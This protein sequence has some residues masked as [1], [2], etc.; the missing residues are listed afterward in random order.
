MNNKPSKFWTS[1]FKWFCKDDFF[2]ELQ[3][4]LEEKFCENMERHGASKAKS[5]YRAEVIKMIRPSVLR[6][7][8]FILN[9]SQLSL[10]QIH[11]KLAFR[12]IYR[13]KVFSAVNI[14]GLAAAL[15]ASLFLV[16]ILYTGHTLDSHHKDSHRIYR[17]STYTHDIKSGDFKLATVSYPLADKLRNQIPEM[18]DLT[19][20]E[21]YRSE[22]FN[23][24]GVETRIKGLHT[25]PSFFELFSFEP[26]HGDIALVFEDHQSIAITDELSKRLF[27]DEDP[28][29]KV[30]QNGKVVRAII[31]SPLGKSHINFDFIGHLDAKKQNITSPDGDLWDP[32][33]MRYAYF[34]LASGATISKVNE[35]L[36][37]LSSEINETKLNKDRTYQ[38]ASQYITDIIFG[39]EEYNSLGFF[40]S[41]KNSIMFYVL[42]GVLL[43]LACFNYTNMSVARA[44]Q[45]TKEISIRKVAGSKRSQII[46]QFL[47][48]TVLFSLIGLFLGILLY[49][50]F[51]PQF[52]LMVP[53][54]VPVI[55]PNI[56]IEILLVF[57]L[58]TSL[59]GLMAGII[60][61]LYFANTSPL[62]IFNSKVK[63]KR[64]SLLTLRKVLVTLQLTLSMFC[65]L[66]IS[67]GFSQYQTLISTRF[68]FQKEQVVSIK[69]DKAELPLLKQEF[70]RIPEVKAI[71][72]ASSLPGMEL[73]S[74]F[75]LKEVGKM[76]SLFV[77]I[78]TTDT[79]FEQVF[80]P[81]LLRGEFFKPKATGTGHGQMLVDRLFLSSFN[82]PEE[83]AI[84]R[85]FKTRN[86]TIQYEITGVLDDFVLGSLISGRHVPSALIHLEQPFMPSHLA[87]RLQQGDAQSALD[88]LEAAW[89]EIKP[90]E[91][92]MPVFLD[93]AIED[94]YRQLQD[95]IKLLSFL[96]IV[97]IGI[98]LLGQLGMALYN[99]ET[100]VKEIGVR[101]VLGARLFSIV[102]LLLKSTLIS[103]VIA[104]VIATPGIIYFFREVIF[105]GMRVTTD[106]G[107]PELGTGIL[108]LSLFVILLVVIQTRKI[109]MAN[110]AESL[111][112]E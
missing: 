12:N 57:I 86:S 9:L 66:F 53:D 24:D 30:T 3:G 104:S 11:L 59:V 100:R 46:G 97:I 79:D 29:G 38:L 112:N 101:K 52:M 73:V 62:A 32:M 42:L 16:N 88:K 80:E 106:I 36:S 63:S 22:I 85:I 40:M 103:L 50:A 28:L 17:V 37:L 6:T 93:N 81:G 78:A 76:D 31:E 56:N 74:G 21:S 65:I 89:Q 99:A 69:A 64:L 1:L 61:S 84:G 45:R 87:I 102:K 109:A 34:K 43:L 23:V 26:I 54:I 39:D 41:R 105:V 110:P 5:L 98:S 18:S 70:L 94:S 71:S 44:I 14:F 20:I 10:F 95:V 8:K 67:V 107:I 68:N 90:E 55:T 33:G 7:P 48:E 60:P 2:E 4:D 92:F 72:I 35:K 83:E 58:F 91:R 27:P 15:S 108:L 82:I 47:V 96:G 19:E 77:R 25:T 51:L 111:R 75:E 49:K 13:H